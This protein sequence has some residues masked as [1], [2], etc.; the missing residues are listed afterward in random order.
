MKGRGI[1]MVLFPLLALV[2]TAF[3]LS[4]LAEEKYQQLPQEVRDHDAEMAEELKKVDV[5]DLFILEDGQIARV[6]MLGIWPIFE[7]EFMGGINY[8]ETTIDFLS[9]S[10]A[11]VVKKSD[12][13]YESVAANYVHTGRMPVDDRGD[14]NKKGE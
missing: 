8:Q 5:G 13:N 4:S 7:Y 14:Q 1:L 9:R 11:Q 3:F 10:V 6:T 12:P 2:S